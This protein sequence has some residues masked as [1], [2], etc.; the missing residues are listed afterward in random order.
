[1]FEFSRTQFLKLNVQDEGRVAP[2]I[3]GPMKRLVPI[4][5]QTGPVERLAEALTATTPSSGWVVKATNLTLFDRFNPTGK[6]QIGRERFGYTG[7]NRSQ[8]E[9]TGITRALDS[10]TAE[11]HEA[12]DSIYE[13]L[14]TYRY[15][16]CEN[17]RLTHF[18]RSV[19][20][21]YLDGRIL[22]STDKPIV[23]VNLD[24]RTV[25]AGR[26]FVT[27]SVNVSDLTG[28]QV[29]SPGAGL[30]TVGYAQWGVGTTPD[31]PRP[32]YRMVW[33]ELLRLDGRIA[34]AVSWKARYERTVGG[35]GDKG[36]G[37]LQAPVIGT[38]EV[39]VT[40][41]QDDAL[42][43]ITGTPTSLLER[44]AHVIRALLREA[45]GERDDANYD[46]TSFAT[47]HALQLADGIRWR[48][49]FEGAGFAGWTR[50]VL[51]AGKAHLYNNGRWRYVYRARPT[52]VYT[53][54]TDDVPGG[55]DGPPTGPTFS[56]TPRTDLVTELTVAYDVGLTRRTFPLR[57]QSAVD[58]SGIQ[59]AR[60]LDLE[61]IYDE[62]IAQFLGAYWLGQWS[63]QRVRVTVDT[64]WRAIGLEGY[65]GFTCDVPL[66]TTWGKAHMVFLLTDVGF[67]LDDTVLSIQGEE[68]ESPG[69]AL[70]GPWR[71]ALPRSLQLLG[72][73]RLGTPSAAPIGTPIG[74]GL[75]PGGLAG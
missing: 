2:F 12:G 67:N 22:K 6:I 38:L 42:G 65:D 53:F 29:Q 10:T 19:D 71:I 3:F 1:M 17:P 72:A 37:D 11:G 26:S 75:T 58:R 18:T 56:F 24:D 57:D 50:D 28:E 61:W 21:V 45:W 49:A 9:F 25:V 47:T 32:G 33:F 8:L 51:L 43:T 54:T 5:Y 60:S 23:T 44:P 64:P 15:V 48:L 39:D 73:W 34:L 27:L 36:A 20:Q 7:K 68:G 70:R 16:V 69:L 35:A 55:E 14:A 59:R 62:P 31:P 74:P 46:L 66:M 52:S 40:G 41:L 13:V 63:R 30:S 4:G